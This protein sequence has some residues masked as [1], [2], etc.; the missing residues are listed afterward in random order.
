[1]RKTELID[2]SLAGALGN[3]IDRTAMHP[4]GSDVIEAF[5]PQ[6]IRGGY[7]TGAELPVRAL[8]DDLL[9]G[10]GGLIVLLGRA[11]TPF[12]AAR[13]ALSEIT[14]FPPKHTASRTV[15]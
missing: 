1:M 9:Q 12:R 10:S 3:K 15:F 7:P 11:R 8:P 4:G 2:A 6:W 13:R 5:S 14:A